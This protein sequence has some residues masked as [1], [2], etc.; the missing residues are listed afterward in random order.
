MVS[1]A[2]GK[3]IP[4]KCYLQ[5]FT[6]RLHFLLDWVKRKFTYIKLDYFFLV[7]Q[8]CFLPAASFCSSGFFPVFT[9]SLSMTSDSGDQHRKS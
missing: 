6:V 7:S 1:L 4:E 2:E 5:L 8:K 3:D 9:D